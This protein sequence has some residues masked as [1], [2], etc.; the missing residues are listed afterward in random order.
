MSEEDAMTNPEKLLE[1]GMEAARETFSRAINESLNEDGTV[2]LDAVQQKL[3]EITQVLQDAAKR[4]AQNG[5]V[6][7]A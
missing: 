4:I 2:N 5:Q 1:W 7:D 6:P 3:A